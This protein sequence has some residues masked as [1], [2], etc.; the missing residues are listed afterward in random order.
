MREEG[1]AC[2]SYCTRAGCADGQIKIDQNVRKI[3][4]QD[5]PLQIRTLRPELDPAIEK[6]LIELY[7]TSKSLE[8]LRTAHD[9]TA[10]LERRAAQLGKG[11]GLD[12]RFGCGGFGACRGQCFGCCRLAG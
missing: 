5:L 8:D 11:R 1:I 7:A 6:Y 12:R 10:R 9:Q 3:L 2:R 4:F